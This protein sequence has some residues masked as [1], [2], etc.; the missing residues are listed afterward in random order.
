MESKPIPPHI[1]PLLEGRPVAFMTTMRPDGQ[2]ST[3]PV[4]LVYDGTSIRVSTVTTR[5]KY[6]NL[7][8]DDRITLCVVQADNLNRFVEI[9]GRAT[10]VPDTDREFINTIARNYMGVDHYPFDRPDYQRVVV[11]VSVDH[12]YSPSVPLADKPPYLAG[13][14]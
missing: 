10:V 13:S 7:L 9:R 6:K 4:A 2:M 14:T 3:T 12:I 5:Q 8:A 11:T 1:V